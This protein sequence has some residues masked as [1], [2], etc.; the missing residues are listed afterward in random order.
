MTQQAQDAQ[1]DPV[2]VDPAQPIDPVAKAATI[3]DQITE[4]QA[5]ITDRQTAIDALNVIA[6]DPTQPAPDSVQ[7]VLPESID[8]KKAQAFSNYFSGLNGFVQ[9]E[10]IGP[11]V[12]L[13]TI[14]DVLAAYNKTDGVAAILKAYGG[15]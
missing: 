7:D 1:A 9:N 11:D 12:T 6:A 8:A 10:Y 4:L 2:Q 14:S 13:T 3:A 15:Q 5:E